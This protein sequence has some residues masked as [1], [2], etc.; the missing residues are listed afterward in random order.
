[1]WTLVPSVAHVLGDW[2][3]AEIFWPLGDHLLGVG[4]KGQTFWAAG[5]KWKYSGRWQII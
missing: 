1:V 3:K 2:A 4:G 5:P